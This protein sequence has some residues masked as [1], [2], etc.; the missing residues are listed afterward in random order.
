MTIV[1]ETVTFRRNVQNAMESVQV[2]RGLK[3]LYT[4]RAL[5]SHQPLLAEEDRRVWRRQ[6]YTPGQ[7]YQYLPWQ[8]VVA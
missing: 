5:L 1:R 7:L 4:R 8:Y 2:H 3:S 6:L